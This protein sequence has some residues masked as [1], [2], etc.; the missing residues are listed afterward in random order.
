MRLLIV[1]DARMARHPAPG[2]H[3]ERPARLPPT[4]AGAEQGAWRS[5]AQVHRE[6]AADPGSEALLRVHDLAYLAA[7]EAVA[8]TGEE[9]FLDSDTAFGTGSLEAARLAAGA[10]L[11]AAL[12]VAGDEAEVAFAVVRPP[13]HHARRRSAAGFCLFNSVAIAAEGLRHAERARRIAIV[14]WDLHHGDGTQAL[15]DAD[16]DLCYTSTHQYPFYPGTGAAGERGSGPAAGTKHNVPLAAGSGDDLFVE[17]WRGNLLPA[18]E[19]FVP[20]AVLVSAGFDAHRNDPIGGLDVTAAGY[21]A[22]ARELGAM[23]R[24]LGLPGVALTLEGGYDLDALRESAAAT[25]DGL[26]AG[27]GK[28]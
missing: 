25:V 22:V 9:G 24:R 10:T 4:V 12:A 23:T 15:Y 19:A 16:P 7:L 21:G 3:P 1:T 5:G 27:M 28:A 14:D 8:A 20:E 18:V 11:R 13:G 2:G 26:I 17:A 6:E